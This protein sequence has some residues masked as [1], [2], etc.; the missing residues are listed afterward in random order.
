[1]VAWCVF[2]YK[3]YLLLKNAH[4]SSFFNFLWN[5]F[6]NIC[7]FIKFFI[8]ITRHVFSQ[9]YFFLSFLIFFDIR[10][11]K[12]IPNYDQFFFK[13]LGNTLTTLRRRIKN[14][15]YSTQST[16]FDSSLTLSLSF[17]SKPSWN[18]SFFYDFSHFHHHLFNI[19]K[20]LHKT[21]NITF[22]F[23]FSK[24]HKTHSFFFLNVF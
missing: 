9:T 1:M 13:V 10:Q 2:M 19:K 20:Y 7:V 15:W 16:S 12:N 14:S 11:Q 18:A 22:F 4:I 5:S 6:I 24:L 21:L 17:V 8:S 3:K 23:V